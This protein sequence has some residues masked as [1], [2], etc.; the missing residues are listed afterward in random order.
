MFGK[1]KAPL[2]AEISICEVAVDESS[3]TFLEA[4]QRLIRR[5]CGHCGWLR[6]LNFALQYQ[7]G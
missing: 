4:A 6:G 2:G 7:A 3:V 5:Y 1:C